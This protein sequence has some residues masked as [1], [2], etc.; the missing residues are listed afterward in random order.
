ML[1][2]RRTRSM[3]DPPRTRPRRYAA[4]L[5]RATALALGLAVLA[6]PAARATDGLD[7]RSTNTYVVDAKKELVRAK[8]TITVRNTKANVNLGGGRYYY[9]FF[10]S[11]YLPVPADAEQVKATSGG[12]S[13]PVSLTKSD[14]PT[15]K[16]ATIAFP[17]ELLYG[18]TRKI[19]L[20]FVAKGAKPRSKDKTRVGPGYATF[21]VYCL[22]DP[23]HTTTNVVL[24]TTMD[25][26]A[27]TDSFSPTS[28]KGAV[29]YT[30]T[31]TNDANGFW[32]V[33][34]ARNPDVAATTQVKIGDEDVEV[35]AYQDDPGWAPFVKKG[36]TQ[37][38]PV[39][40]K[41][42][43]TTW[44]GGLTKVREDSSVNV[45][46][47]DGWFDSRSDEIVI[48]EDLDRELLFHELSHAWA[49]SS[50][51]EQRWIYEGLAQTLAARTVRDLGGTSAKPP[52]VSRTSKAAV[53]LNAWKED[54]G[55]SQ[56]DNDYGYPAAYRA[57]RDLLNGSD[58][59]RTSALL[60][61]VLG[62]TSA[63]AASTDK[64]SMDDVTDWRR[65]LDLLETTGGNTRAEKVY[66]TWVL[67]AAQKKLLATRTTA[68]AAYEK[69]DAADGDF[70]PPL[71]VRSEMTSWEFPTAMVAMTSLRD[72]ADAAVALQDAAEQHGM[73][74]PQ[75]VR[76][77][78]EQATTGSDYDALVGT[79]DDATQAIRAVA[80]SDAAAGSS[81][82]PLHALGA[83]L[84]G[85]DRKAVAADRL[86]AA[87]DVAG[88]LREAKA[89]SD[90][91]GS[92][93][94]LGLA[95][96]LGVLVLL[97]GVVALVLLLRRVLRRRP[98]PVIPA[99]PAM[100]MAGA[101]AGMPGVDGR[102]AGYA[103]PGGPI[104]GAPTPGPMAEGPVPTEPPPPTTDPPPWQLPATGWG[105]PDGPASGEAPPA[106]EPP[107]RA[108]P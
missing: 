25:F 67:T 30:S 94:W 2:D 44:P 27:T 103:A 98:T 59:A 79:L 49:S 97:G 88:A 23:G 34:S 40:E 32:A 84:L 74:V 71:G 22:G 36:M 42:T 60:A 95:L 66:R 91:A 78:Y 45:R 86:L 104:P 33:I 5:R 11:V 90:A 54:S 68:R 73:E 100:A 38:I 61:A 53:A 70:A 3:P 4:R 77:L 46:G 82:N 20:T 89:A 96:V 102:A 92:A 14:S 83:T 75:S 43:G 19:T 18:Q 1:A 57:M 69:L 6:A 52:A 12:S 87:G 58:E 93:T 56:S 29:T 72:A 99:P 64:G 65:F 85:V 108:T 8:L 106:A 48:G 51:I 10:R 80:A 31:E 50:A 39:L 24:P 62:G 47:Y 26:D 17:Q 13:L 28:T 7:V 63:Y 107:P 76:A 101:R 55:R 35:M 81:S 21:A 41:L 16:I 9:Y 15:L 37:G 105:G